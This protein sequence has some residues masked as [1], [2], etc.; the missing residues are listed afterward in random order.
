MSQLHDHV[1]TAENAS[2][3]RLLCSFSSYLHVFG[4]VY[5]GSYRNSTMN[6]NVYMIIS[7]PGM[8]EFI[9]QSIK[10]Q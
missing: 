9:L 4:C 6:S 2:V 1:D 5:V 10:R 8:S 7:F 3:R